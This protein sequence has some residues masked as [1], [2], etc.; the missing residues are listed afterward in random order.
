MIGAVRDDV[1]VR[2]RRNAREILTRH[3][4]PGAG[5]TIS[6]GYS[7]R[8]ALLDDLLVERQDGQH[9]RLFVFHGSS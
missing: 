9:V 2:E 4:L 1:L 3:A 8:R 7:E 6:N 5:L